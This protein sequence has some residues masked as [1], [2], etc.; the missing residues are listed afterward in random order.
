MVNT[1]RT[2]R[3]ITPPSDVIY[4]EHSTQKRYRFYDALD[5]RTPGKSLR[6]REVSKNLGPHLRHS[7][8]TYQRLVNPEFN[9]V[10]DQAY[11]AQIAYHHLDIKP[12][13][14]GRNLR[15]YTKQARRYNQAYVKKQ[16]SPSNK[17][18]GCNMAMIMS[19][20]RLRSIGLKS[21]LQTSSMLILLP[22]G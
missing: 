18:K 13:Q 5:V 12:R 7:P 8:E 15:R 9:P 17:V 21:S 16:I 1:R 20:T 22:K 4:K 11:E 10:R 19:T 2:R 6:S 14:L 3:D